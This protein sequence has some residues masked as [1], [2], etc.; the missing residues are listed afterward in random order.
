M[1]FLAS[2]KLSDNSTLRG[3]II[4]MLV[5]FFIAMMLSLWAKGIDF[6]TT[7]ERWVATVMG[8]PE[9]FS[10]P[11]LW[12]DLLLGIHADL[13]ALIITF[14]LIAS[15]YVRTSRATVVKITLFSALLLTLLLY[16][17]GLL[18]SPL[19]GSFSI[20]TALGSFAVFHLLIILMS[21][22]LLIGLIQKRI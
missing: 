15:L 2:K 10:E 4:W 22:D 14:I 7:P 9:E 5:L 12:S 6:G 19:L 13:F 16:P 17:V 8:N 18:A 1:K 20:I 11:M 21:V 3:V